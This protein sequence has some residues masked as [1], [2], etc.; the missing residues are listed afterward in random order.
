MKW[1]MKDPAFGDMVRIKTGGIYHYGVYVSDDEVIQFGLAP[2]QRPT[3]KNS[4]V[5]V[6]SS[7][8]DTFLSGSFLEVAEFDRKEKKKNRTPQAAVALAR[9]RLGTR[10]YDILYNNCEHFANECVT[11]VHYSS[12]SD[13]LRAMFRSMPVVD[14][15]LAALPDGEISEALLPEAREREVAA[16]SHPR[17]KREKYYVWRLLEYALER[18]FGF[19]M[20]DM[21]FEKNEHGKWTS[22]T[23]FFSLSHT[24]GALAVA[25]SRAA[26][27]VDIERLGEKRPEGLA[28]RIL[29]EAELAEMEALA[30]DEREDYLIERWTAK[31]AW[32]KYGNDA[33][34]APTKISPDGQKLKTDRVRFDDREYCYS[35][36]TD[37]VSRIRVYPNVELD[38]K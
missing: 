34:F 20:A 27:G 16:A 3:V 32:F 6:V 5:E 38:K 15:Y 26:V 29:T 22:P 14:V 33:T 19:R 31:E 23:C 12:Q 35:V 28:A 9:E 2:A 8:I 30:A 17:V 18:S 10:G 25:V 1:L 24:D 37:T 7:D 11:G 13:G 36:A 21:T 4:E